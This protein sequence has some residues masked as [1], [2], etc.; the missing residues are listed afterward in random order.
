MEV[1]APIVVVI[2]FFLAR[3]MHIRACIRREASEHRERRNRI[4]EIAMQGLLAGGMWDRQGEASLV[5]DATRV[6]D[7]LIEEL[8]K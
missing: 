6:A 4:V 1:L 2:A 3:E 5:F 8:D 7:A